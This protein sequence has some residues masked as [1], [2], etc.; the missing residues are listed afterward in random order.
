MVELLRRYL[1]NICVQSGKPPDAETIESIEYRNLAPLYAEEQMRI[2][3]RRRKS[4]EWD[5]VVQGKQGGLAVRGLARIRSHKPD[6]E[7]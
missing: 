2:S 6:S 1:E 4:G 7:S 3:G 5:M